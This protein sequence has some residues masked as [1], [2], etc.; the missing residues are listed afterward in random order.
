MKSGLILF[1][2]FLASSV[3]LGVHLE[4]ESEIRRQEGR[5]MVYLPPPWLARYA[6]MGHTP[7]IADYVWMQALQY[8]GNNWNR[9]YY[10][11]DLHRYIDLVNELDPNFRYAYRFGAASVPFNSGRWTWHNVEASNRIIE[12]GLERFPD[13]WQL[14]LQLGF[15]RGVLQRDYVGAAEAYRR[16]AAVPGAPLW[17]PQ[18]V[19]RL[20]STVGSL[21]QA[22]AYTEEILLNTDQPEMQEAMSRRLI[23]IEIE[24]SLET[25]DAAIEQYQRERGAD[26]DSISALIASGHLS[27]MPTD[28]LGGS[29]YIENGEARSSSLHGGRLRVFEDENELV[30]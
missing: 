25:V 22:K 4:R 13:D 20:Y 1:A 28:R 2:T 14:L 5:E 16:A 19:T 27:R 26:P 10:F 15:N 7:L 29:F 8:Y 6:S 24:E 18:L 23:E 21:E 12:R 30:Q 17:I 11:R 3:A 9:L